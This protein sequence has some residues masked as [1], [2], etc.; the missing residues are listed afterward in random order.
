[1]QTSE[2]VI[3]ADGHVLE[4]L[5]LDPD[6]QAE[7][8]QRL[9]GDPDLEFDASALA[10]LSEADDP[11]PMESSHAE[12]MYIPGA[13]EPEARLKDMTSEGMDIAVLYPTTPGLGFIPGAERFGTM[14]RAYNEWLHQFCQADTSRLIGVGLVPLQDPQAAIAEMERCVEE[15]GFKAVMIRPAPYIEQ[16]KLNE[17]V[18]DPFWAA[19][20]SVGCP[21]GV[22]PFPF[23]DMPNVV[24]LLQLHEDGHGNPS[25]GL[26][27]KQGLGNAL[28]VMVAM[29]WF[30]A[31]GICER[32]PRLKV[33]FLEG[34]GGWCSPMLERFDH[35]IDVFGS[36][37]QKTPPSEVFRSQCYISF[38]PDEHA[39]AY[40]A[41]SPYV[42]A[43]R[44]LW[45][46][47]YPHPDAKIPGVVEELRKATATLTD[48][49][50]RLI[51]GENAATFYGL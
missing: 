23:P 43:D 47:D 40:T 44:I 39:L 19:A 41:N 26:A 1:M 3:D 48:E 50:R 30:V 20:Q 11:L 5:E 42:G 10:S 16:K 7:F 15:L 28:D 21:I 27:L 46:S 9:F 17:P 13:Y 12:R 38:D 2:R 22:H 35:H 37:Y 33:A 14:C 25:K 45:A 32:F 51:H 4:Q 49:Q 29:G 36:R 34:S 8:G 24:S 18:Y 31:G 6:I